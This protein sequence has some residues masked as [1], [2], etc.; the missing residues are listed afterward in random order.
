[1]SDSDIVLLSIFFFII[2]F[3]YSLAGFGGGSSY[4]AILV[5]QGI[6]Q[7]FI[8]VIALVC[9]IIVVSG[10]VFHFI[11]KR[12][13]SFKFLL[14]F[15]ILS[16][17]CAYLGG[18]IPIDKKYYQIILGFVL[19]TISLY[20]F[21]ND[22][23]LPKRNFIKKHLLISLFSGGLL[24]FLSGLV[25]I[26]GGI[27]LSPLLYTLGWGNAKRIAATASAFILINSCAGLIGQIQKING[28]V[29]FLSGLPLY[30]SVLLGGQL[31]SWCCNYRIS[32][33]LVVKIT[34]LLVFMASLRLLINAWEG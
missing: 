27:I 28:W 29:N 2:A 18:S 17:P 5:L 6:S 16:I 12:H 25:G 9:N 1:M 20:M 33:R 4:I 23:F 10:G 31:G 26:G 14:P 19:F 13:F 24:G 15:I 30:V 21:F 7:K 8:P 11:K 34:A 22:A 3:F 32:S